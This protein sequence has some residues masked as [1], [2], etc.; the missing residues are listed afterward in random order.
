MNH[1]PSGAPDD[2][3]SLRRNAWVFPEQKVVWVAIAKNACTS[4]KWMLADMA[5]EDRQRIYT[6]NHAE[7]SRRMCIHDRDLWQNVKYPADLEPDLAAEISPDNGWFIFTVVR[8]P[9]VRAWSAWQSKFLQRD[10]IYKRKFPS[11]PW[12]PRLPTSS[13]DVI[14]DFKLFTDWVATHPRNR[15]LADPHFAL[16]V[17]RVDSQSTPYSKVYDIEDLAELPTDLRSHLAN[18]GIDNEVTLGRDND[19]YLPVSGEVFGGGVREQLEAIYARDLQRFGARWDFDN[20]MAKR[21]EWSKAAFSAIADHAAMGERIRDILNVSAEM[22]SQRDKARSELRQREQVPVT[23][24]AEDVDLRRRV[25]LL[26]ELTTAQAE[27]LEGQ[28]RQ[29]KRLKERMAKIQ[30]APKVRRPSLLA[31]LSRR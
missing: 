5:G 30:S 24:S 4:I 28:K 16:Q 10:P 14:E 23:A 3:P 13:E 15:V 17:D 6:S 12:A 9:R 20:I 2:R 27:T 8:D 29:M 1:S 25:D 19:T 7:V 31:R 18:L 21:P 26:Y 11:P 22:R